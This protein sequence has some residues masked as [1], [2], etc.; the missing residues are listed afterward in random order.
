MPFPATLALPGFLKGG[1]M[2]W[3]IGTGFA[4]IGALVLTILLMAS[5]KET[6]DIRKQRDSLIVQINDPKTGYVAQLSQSRTN[7]VQLTTAIE[8]QKI[9]FREREAENIRVLETTRK[10]LNAAQA[11]SRKAQAEVRAFLA[12]PPKGNTA[13]ERMEDIDRRILEDLKS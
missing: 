3:K 6:S 5:Y 9:Q 11:E 10:K 13:A 1:A 12:T 8:R 4:V 2:L 7:V